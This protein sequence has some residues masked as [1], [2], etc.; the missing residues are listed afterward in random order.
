M[1]QRTSTLRLLIPGLLMGSAASAQQFNFENGLLPG[2][3]RWSEG[4]EA[5]DVD[6]DGDLD[7]CFSE[8]EGFSGPGAQR[9]QVLLI[10]QLV[11][12]G[13][14]SFTNESVARLG[15]QLAHG[16]GVTQGDVNGDGWVDLLY[17]NAFNS[18]TPFLFINRGAAQPG[19]F[20]MESATRG[21]TENLSSGGA[22]FGDLDD[23]G[24]LDVIIC[25]SGA[26][27]LGGAGD[28]PRLFFND[29]NGFFT[30]DAASLNAPIKRAHMDV[31]LVDLDGNWTVDFVGINR[32]TNGGGNHF[33]MLN[34]G[35]GTFTDVSNLFDDTS[36]SVYEAEVAD[37]DGDD[38]VDLYFVSLSGFSEGPMENTFETGS[39]GFTN[40]ATQNNNL[41]DNEIGLMDFDDDGDLDVFIARLGGRERLFSNDGSLTFSPNNPLIEAVTDST[42]DLT[43]GDLDNDGD[44]DLIT[45]Q[46]ESIA[47]NWVNKVYLNS[48]PADTT[49]PRLVGLNVPSS[50]SAWPVII[51]SKHADSVMDDG[52]DYVSAT[53][54]AAP[55]GPDETQVYGG[56]GTG[57]LGA[58]LTVTSGT[59][60]LFNNQGPA[61]MV[62]VVSGPTDISFDLPFNV[63]TPFTFVVPG[64]FVLQESSGD[65][66]TLN[67]VGTPVEVGGLRMGESQSRFAVPMLPAV[68]SNAFGAEIE[69]RDYVGNTT[70]VNIESVDYPG[71]STTTNYC[72]PA[73]A[74][75]SGQSAVISNSGSTT[76]SDMNFGLVA[77][78]LPVN[79]FGFFL[80]SDTQG[81]VL[82]PGNSTGNLC[83]SGNIGR[84]NAQIQNSG[85]GGSISI[86]VDLT[87]LPVNPAQAV[88]P[89][90]TWNF[91]GWFR[92]VG[93]TSNLTDGLSVT[94]Q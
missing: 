14:L 66:F 1:L 67:V 46:G 48:G 18:D 36:G 31:H 11:E 73:V 74:N 90:Q 54:Y 10:N 55:Q 27:Y 87:A 85:P 93:S 25:D 8:G 40:G 32:A 45:A 21:F 22:Q 20:D 62:S 53:L 83:L 9:Q 39:L 7:L 59:R 89:G 92:D 28:E 23:D 29:G 33:V 63:N 58:M 12:T 86:L 6:R 2:T 43:L 35:A 81:F 26:S 71:G 51:K 80:V 52:V 69:L 17:V 24:D 41:D 78:N 61:T 49:N 5:V 50:S 60:V 72:G 37:L 42:L 88:L 75:S 13:S 38:D 15:V 77:S 91:Q 68:A 4:V 16:R 70:W 65:T 44:Y 94:F 64:T 19:F 84:F 3:P 76:V 79:Q 82:M 56:P 34:N 30:E 57:W 47:S